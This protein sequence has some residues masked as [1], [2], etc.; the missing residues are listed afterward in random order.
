M[1]LR[2]IALATLLSA[3]LA[4]QAQSSAP[5]LHVP[6]AAQAGPGF[7][8]D[9]ATRAWL[10]TMHPEQKTRS[11]SY[12]EGG[13]W[14][15]LWDF[16][17]G[18]AI[19]IVLLATRWSARMRDLAERI[20]RFRPLQT[21]LYWT[22]YSVV[23][24]ILGYP[25]TVYEGFRREH[26][27]GL[28]NQTFGPWMG[29][30][31]K[32]LA[33]G[34]I[35]GGLLVT[36]LFGI[37]RRLPRTWHIWGAVA[38]IV[39]LA[40]VQLIAPVYIAPLFNKYT[41][42][43]D[44]RIRD[45]IL[46][47]ARQNGIPAKDVWEVDA[48]RQ[49]KRVSAN[50]SGFLGTERITLNDNLLNRCSPQAIQAVMGH[51]MGHYVLNHV[52]KGLAWAVIIVVLA[53]AFLR[54]A[55]LWSLARWGARWKIRD[56]GDVAVLP[57]AVLIFSI[58]F[59]VLTPVTNTLSRTDEYEAD[60]FGL[61]TARQ[62]DGF[63]EAAILLGEYRKMEPGPLEEFIFYDHPSGYTRIHAAMRWKAEN[64]NPCGAGSQPAAAS[65]AAQH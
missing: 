65:Q 37:V 27:Y 11:D 9:A 59:F 40:F 10:A 22:Q 26:Q 39:F 55:L 23:T 20:T 18:A 28:S 31:G 30:Q 50:V 25:L 16:L 1:L 14:L 5:A 45:P 19:A 61:N 29:D 57:L 51:E 3:L 54:L 17:Y 33:V 49:S 7:N 63:A 4:A 48:S 47:L 41:L 21:F 53:F 62:P 44:A 15:I 32:E 12:F 58:I 64:L 24:F 13:Y 6:A 56:L 38:A 60:M 46:R 2:L 43:Q 35:L 8:V 36:M 42:L 34:I 52:Y